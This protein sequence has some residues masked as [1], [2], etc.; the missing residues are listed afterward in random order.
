MVITIDCSSD[1][2]IDRFMLRV[3]YSNITSLGVRAQHVLRWR[4]VIATYKDTLNASLY[5]PDAPY[6]DIILNVRPI[7]VTTLIVTLCSMA[8]VC[9]F[10]VPNI[11]A[12]IVAIGAIASIST[13]DIIHHC[14]Q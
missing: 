9:I 11:V 3:A 2:H 14:V 5:D 1:I 12:L 10:F 13:G 6:S 8:V 4:A 7:T